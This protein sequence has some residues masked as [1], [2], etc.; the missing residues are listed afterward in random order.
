LVVWTTPT[1]AARWSS[2]KT[3]QRAIHSHAGESMMIMLAIII[4]LALAALITVVIWPLEPRANK[5]SKTREVRR[6]PF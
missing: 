5:Q 6:R 1:K 4:I 3:R 2:R